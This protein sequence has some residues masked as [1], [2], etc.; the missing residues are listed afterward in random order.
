MASQPYLSRVS[1]TIDNWTAINIKFFFSHTH[2]RPTSIPTFQTSQ[3]KKHHGPLTYLTPSLV[4]HGERG[5]SENT[6]LD[7]LLY[8]LPTKFATYIYNKEGI[9][10][11]VKVPD[12][13]TATAGFYSFLLGDFVVSQ[14]NG[15]AGCDDHV[16]VGFW[17]C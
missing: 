12:S 4:P 9:K 3:N 2:T 8:A 14:Y 13:A 5:L 6:S 10:V 15:W 11:K 16:L 17:G 1:I 7:D